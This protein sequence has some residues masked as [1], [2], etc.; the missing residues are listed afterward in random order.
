[1]T[2]AAKIVQEANVDKDYFYARAG[3]VREDEKFFFEKN[4]T[5]FE[6]SKTTAD[7]TQSDFN[8]QNRYL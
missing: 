4:A 2:Q 7:L 3:F 6:R 5:I 8:F 1:M